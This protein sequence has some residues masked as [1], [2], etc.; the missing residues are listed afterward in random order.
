[1]NEHGPIYNEIDGYI[2]EMTEEER[3]E[4]A[5]ADAAIELA[6]LFHDAREARGLTQAEAARRT[7]LR[8]QAV[9]RFEQPDT[10]LA[11]TKFETLRKYLTALGYSIGL[12]VRDAYSGALV[13]E[14]S[15]EPPQHVGIP[16]THSV[17]PSLNTLNTYDAI[18]EALMGG[19]GEIPL[20]A[21]FNFVCPGVK[22]YGG[23]FFATPH[24]G[25][26]IEIKDCDTAIEVNKYGIPHHGSFVYGAPP[27]GSFMTGGVT[28]GKVTGGSVV[29]DAGSRNV[30][31]GAAA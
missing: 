18:G 31:Q 17:F 19:Y 13:K 28:A 15:F 22:A 27:P 21:T 23:G 25:N 29:R 7:G 9:S 24:Y 5:T 2:S 12:S 11:K 6:F 26:V 4:L 3:E 20:G 30:K 1:M 16:A 10:K 14:I 8:Q